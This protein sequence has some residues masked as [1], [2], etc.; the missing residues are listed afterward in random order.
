MSQTLPGGNEVVTLLVLLALFSAAII[1]FIMH[2]RA[3]WRALRH[4]LFRRLEGAE[5]LSKP[6]GVAARLSS[7]RWDAAFRET[8]ERSQRDFEAGG[9][10]TAAAILRAVHDGG[11]QFP[12]MVR[13]IASRAMTPGELESALVRLEQGLVY[14]LV[15][16]GRYEDRRTLKRY[17]S[18]ADGWPEHAA[19]IR[20]AA[21][22]GKSPMI[23]LLYFLGLD[24]HD[25][26]LLVAYEGDDSRRFPAALGEPPVSE[27]NSPA[28][29]YD[30]ALS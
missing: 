20:A 16:P 28:L 9:N 6:S 8:L 4:K 13:D 7:P 24:A 15:L 19:S 23:A 21:G 5:K 2:T 12:E 1:G 14:V 27:L 3:E 10:T 18:L 17:P 22:A 29:T 25:G 11:E 26:S 30:F